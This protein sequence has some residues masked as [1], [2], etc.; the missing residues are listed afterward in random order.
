[1]SDRKFTTIQV[2]LNAGI[3]ERLHAFRDRVE[4]QSEVPVRVTLYDAVDLAVKEAS[5][6]RGWKTGAGKQGATR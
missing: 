5:K 1:M 3:M 6:A 4:Q 2:P